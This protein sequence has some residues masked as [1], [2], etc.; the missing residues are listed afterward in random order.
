VRRD[1]RETLQEYLYQNLGLDFVLDGWVALKPRHRDK[2][3]VQQGQIGKCRQMRLEA[4]RGQVRVDPNSQIVC[5]D[6]KNMITHPTRIVRVV[7]ERLGIR[8]QQVL[9]GASSVGRRGCSTNRRMPQVQRAGGSVAG[10]ITG[11]G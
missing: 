5:R 10:Q 8:Q 4:D 3:H 6:L 2:I 1:S 7:R 11:F 9:A